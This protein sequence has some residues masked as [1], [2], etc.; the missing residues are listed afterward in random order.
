MGSEMQE[1][2]AFL[3]Q[4]L[5]AGA[6][7]GTA[8]AEKKGPSED[9]PIVLFEKPVQALSYDEIGER[10]AEMGFDGIEATIRK[11]GHI[12]PSKAAKEVPAMLKSL[13]K[14]GLH[15]VIAE[16]SVTGADKATEELLEVLKDNGNGFGITLVYRA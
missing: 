8:R 16:T 5:A 11:G 12:D 4:A 3:K 14:S 9:W 7:A 13:G 6:L 1:R 2:R 10:L 15:T